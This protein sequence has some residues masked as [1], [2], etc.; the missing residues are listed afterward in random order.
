VLCAARVEPHV[1][2]GQIWVTEEFREQL[3]RQP[4]RWRTSPV[5]LSGGD[6]RFNASKGDEPDRWVRL[7]RLEF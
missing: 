4:S 6:D 2:P 7:Y 3:T 5:V 1:E